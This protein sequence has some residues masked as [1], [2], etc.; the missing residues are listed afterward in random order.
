MELQR[1]SFLIGTAAALTMARP[2]RAAQPMV[3]GVPV[4]QTGGLADSAAHVYK[5][6]Q[7]WQDQINAKGGLLKRPVEFKVYDDRSDPATAAKLTERLIVEDK[8][9]LLLSPYG[10]AATATASAVSEKHGVVMMNIA[11][12]A[13][14]IHLR[15]FKYIFQVVAP[16]GAYVEGAYP[17]AQPAGYKSL[18]CIGSDYDASRAA[19]KAVTVL[20]PKRNID[21][22]MV[23]YFTAGTVDFSPYI[24]RARD[25]KPDV[26]LSM[27]YPPEAIEMVK[28]MKAN[29]YLP[30][31]FVHNGVSQE[32]F[33][34]ATGKDSEYAFGISLYEPELKTKNNAEFVRT[35]EQK[36]G[37]KP[38]YYA[39]D[40][41]AAVTILAEAVNRVGSTDQNKLR[42]TLSTLEMETPFGPYKVDRTT[43]GQIAKR[44]MI[45][46][47]LK[48]KREIIWPFN[49]ASAKAVMP[50]PAWSARA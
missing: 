37:Y 2:A 36:W 5:A 1:R 42:D 22:Q 28:Q 43:G 11:G 20:A 33:L 31:M 26:W 7:L 19:D 3:I 10:S 30:N 49:L 17:V 9:D 25:L 27:G 18:V 4:S 8:V 13:E 39:A 40:G 16:R 21:V 48:G 15:G 47:V 32:D 41:F 6:L 14:D 12:S 34:K 38:G 45:V 35:F 29:N 24:A 46:Q 44:G 23:E 50:M